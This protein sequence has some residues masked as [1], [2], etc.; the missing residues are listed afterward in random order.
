[1]APRRCGPSPALTG[2][3][4]A[5]W[6]HLISGVVISAAR[7]SLPPPPSGSRPEDGRWG[8]GQSGV[9]SEGTQKHLDIGG[10]KKE[11]PT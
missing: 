6:S 2:Q 5:L 10:E 9:R 8:G 1:M 7:E 4:V 11:A 3:Q